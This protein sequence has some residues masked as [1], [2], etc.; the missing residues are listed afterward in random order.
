MADLLRRAVDVMTH[1][2][3]EKDLTF[4]L[5]VDA[6]LAPVLLGDPHRLNQVM[7]NLLGNAIKFTDA[8]SV[9]V[10]CQCHTV[11]NRQ[12]VII[13]IQDTGIG[14]N[15]NFKQNLF[16]KFTQE[17]GSIGR[18]YGGTGLGMSITKQ[19]I[20]LMGGRIEVDSVKNQGTTIQVQLSFPIGVPENLPTAEHSCHNTA[21]LTK[22]HI[23]LVEDNDMNR[24]VVTTILAAYDITVLEV[25]NGA[26][27]LDILRLQPVDLVLMD[28]QMPVM[29]GLEATR[30]IRSEI[31]ATLPI[32]ALT[33]SAIRTEQEECYK[34]GM[35]GFLAKPFE[36]GELLDILIKWL[37]MS[38]IESES[39][40]KQLYDLS[41]LQAISRGNQEFVQK[42]IRLFCTDVPGLLDQL[43]AA[44]QSADI[45]RVKKLAHRL[46]PSI[47]Y[48][49]ATA[50]G[51]AVR[52]IEQLAL[53][54]PDFPELGNVI[55]SLASAMTVIINQM[56]A[57]QV[58]GGPAL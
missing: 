39:G 46:K 34:A 36:E 20:D 27:A 35:N 56:K 47:D 33:A 31:S 52:R 32:I 42:M 13:S 41:K 30:I 2:A 10:R 58:P 16:A 8:G 37:G 18:R 6:D 44:Y 14:M 50:P 12:Q 57:T 55:D 19:L 23:L 38:Q 7:M 29:D 43:R 51:E 11:A 53:S 4:T 25:A 17:D 26:Q 1:N 3:T 40:E 49:G 5:T 48:M 21:V 15:A 28:V 22:K 24:L 45:E 9:Q 54:E